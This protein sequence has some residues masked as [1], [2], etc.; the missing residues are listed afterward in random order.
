ML[1]GY[2][3]RSIALVCWSRPGGAGRG[4][5]FG[6]IATLSG[7]ISA[8]VAI[9]AVIFAIQFK[10][11]PLLEPS[12]LYVIWHSYPGHGIEKERVSPPS[13]DLYRQFEGAIERLAA[14]T[15]AR[16]VNLALEASGEPGPASQ[17]FVEPALF[18]VLGTT[19][20]SGRLFVEEDAAPASTSNVAILSSEAWHR[21]FGDDLPSGQRLLVD[22]EF[23]E[24]V[25]TLPPDFQ[26][27]ERAD[28]L[29]PLY[30][31]PRQRH[32]SQLG[33]DY[34]TVFSRVNRGVTPA[35]LSRSL[36]ELTRQVRAAY[37][38]A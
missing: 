9:F 27:L 34:L 30:L 29:R 20:S 24:I 17:I 10:P 21:Y 18:S 3:L 23:V 6:V 28:I 11:L 37:P 14:V 15:P 12:N 2:V 13:L 19:P 25:G 8:S 1:V 33:N 22:G 38:L 32:P 35:E 4:N 5:L 31:S 16:G 36:G 7:T 26:L